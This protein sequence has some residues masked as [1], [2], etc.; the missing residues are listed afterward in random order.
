MITI[1]LQCAS[2]GYYRENVRQFVSHIKS[3]GF[4]F[5]GGNF[6]CDGPDLFVLRNFAFDCV[7]LDASLLEERT[8]GRHSIG[9]LKATIDYLRNLS[10]KIV[11]T[12]ILDEMSLRAAHQLGC[13]HGQGQGNESKLTT[14]FS[15]D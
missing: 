3:L 8:N 15:E 13:K 9:F 7:S 5:S 11:V 14:E 6:G 4:S 12:G 2:L 1:Q 10:N